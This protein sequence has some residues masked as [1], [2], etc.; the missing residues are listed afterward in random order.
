MLQKRCCRRKW[1][2]S[3]NPLVRHFDVADLGTLFYFIL[4]SY[5]RHTVNKSHNSQWKKSTRLEANFR[6]DKKT[7]SLPGN[8]VTLRGSTTVIGG[9]RNMLGVSQVR[10]VDTMHDSMTGPR[11]C[12]WD[13]HCSHDCGC[14]RHEW[15]GQLEFIRPLI[16]SFIRP[17][18]LNAS[19][20]CKIM[21][22]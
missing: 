19:P 13:S 9:F 22:L 18:P 15:L 20:L 11:H 8:P 3:S 10:V 4:I 6:N 12:T 1:W 5:R 21:S 17:R 16:S 2:D 14:M 7:M